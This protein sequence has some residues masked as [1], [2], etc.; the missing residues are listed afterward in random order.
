MS[1]L[2]VILASFPLVVGQ[3]FRCEVTSF[4]DAPVV[5]LSARKDMEET[6]AY[7]GRQFSARTNPRDSF[8]LPFPGW[9]VDASSR[10]LLFLRRYRRSFTPLSGLSLF[11]RVSPFYDLPTLGIFSGK[12]IHDSDAVCHGSC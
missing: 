6:F 4:F 9:D 5:T 2:A 1:S 10:F 11:Q 3:L 8:R 7:I 12:A